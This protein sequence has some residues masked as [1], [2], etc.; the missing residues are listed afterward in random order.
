MPKYGVQW[1]IVGSVWVE[2]EVPEGATY[3]DVLDASAEV[4]ADSEVVEWEF[5]DRVATGNVLH[6]PHSEVTV[7]A[8]EGAPRLRRDR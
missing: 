3:Q 8:L 4:A 2:V 7:E 1:P 6:H 5:V